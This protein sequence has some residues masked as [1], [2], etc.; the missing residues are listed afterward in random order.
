MLRPAG[1]F[2]RA[3]L[4]ASLLDGSFLDKPLIAP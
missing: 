4:S 2:E 1:C 3:V